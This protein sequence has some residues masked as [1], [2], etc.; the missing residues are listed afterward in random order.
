MQ[1]HGCKVWITCD[2]QPLPEYSTKIEGN[3]GKTISCF[4]PSEAGNSFALHY[5]N[6]RAELHPD[7][8]LRFAPDFDGTSFD[9]S[10][11]R[12]GGEASLKGHRPNATTELPLQF[13]TLLTTDEDVTMDSQTIVELGLIRVKVNRWR[14]A[15]ARTLEEGRNTSSLV[16]SISIS[17]AAAGEPVEALSCRSQGR[18]HRSLPLSV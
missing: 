13:A 14:W 10:V 8:F 2:G 6:N 12:Q 3:D 11:C 9:A 18:L 1:L 17:E 5:H 7:H 15:G 4:V 16:G